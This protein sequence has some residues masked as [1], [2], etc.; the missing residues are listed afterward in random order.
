MYA[1][2]VTDMTDCV[3]LKADVTPEDR[4]VWCRT[5]FGIPWQNPCWCCI[6]TQM[7]W[8]L[9]PDDRCVYPRRYYC[10]ADCD[11]QGL[12]ADKKIQKS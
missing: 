1:H 11:A 7:S 12:Y 8:T 6:V 4:R 10:C 2:D 9:S 3:G 5:L